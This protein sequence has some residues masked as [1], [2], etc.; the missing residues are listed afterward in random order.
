MVG[1]TFGRKRVQGWNS[2][3][4]FW[5]VWLWRWVGGISVWGLFVKKGNILGYLVDEGQRVSFSISF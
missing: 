3:G 4:L 1:L 2:V 5:D